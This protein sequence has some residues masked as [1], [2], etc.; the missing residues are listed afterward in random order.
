MRTDI[1]YE[2]SN[3]IC[4]DI[5]ALCRSANSPK[6]IEYSLL[7]QQQFLNGIVYRVAES[8]A[9][10]YYTS[11]WNTSKVDLY[12]RKIRMLYSSSANK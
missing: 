7:L 10:S 8:E 2:F 6:L 11:N 5:S 4:E 3:D 1:K 12:I 9:P